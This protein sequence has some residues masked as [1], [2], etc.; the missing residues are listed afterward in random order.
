MN[1]YQVK[2]LNKLIS[3]YEKS[4]TH[5]GSNKNTQHFIARPTKLFPEYNDQSDY[6]TFNKINGSLREL[7]SKGYIKLS[8]ASGELISSAELQMKM[9]K[10]IY[11]SLGRKSK[12]DTYSEATV[13]LSDFKGLN[14]ILDKFCSE[15]LSNIDANRSVKYVSSDG[16]CTDLQY[17]LMA[18]KELPNIS[19]ETFYRDFSIRTFGDSKI[20]ESIKDKV[21]SVICSY[22]ETENEETALANMNLVKNPGHV[23]FKGNGLIT[24]TGQVLDLSILDG[25]IGISSE[26]LRNVE[27][28]EAKGQNIITIENLTTFHS[29][30]STDDLIIYLG[31]YHNSLRRDFICRVFKSNPDKNYL[32]FGDIDAG[33]FYILEH[34]RNRTG[35]NF[36]PYL[37]DVEILKKYSKYC[38]PLTDNDR[39]RL[40]A[41]MG[42]GYDDTI[43]YMLEHNCKLEQ[44]AIDF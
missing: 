11:S 37:M 26:M 14:P 13:L 3:T 28:V 2:L 36:K 23:F 33:G 34:L 25:D 1:E 29:Y 9:L 18:L 44:E 16:D 22:D 7:E 42:K 4:K 19:S 30:S 10:E 15:Q 32:H 8:Y 20:F 5:Q 17:I 21:V 12:R 35:I 39:K 38:K 40:N 41:I 43:N 31:G 6:Y 24:L 27:A